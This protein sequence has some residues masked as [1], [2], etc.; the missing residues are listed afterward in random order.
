MSN[1]HTWA[2]VLEHV[3][4][5]RRVNDRIEERVVLLELFLGHVFRDARLKFT[6]SK[7]IQQ[8]AR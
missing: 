1:E 3:A 2:Y 4:H 8:L 7:Y 6:I 5:G